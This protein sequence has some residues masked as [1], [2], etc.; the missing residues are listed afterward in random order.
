MRLQIDNILLVNV[1]N[2]IGLI[3]RVNVTKL[4]GGDGKENAMHMIYDR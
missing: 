1:L 2:V 3:T 4:G